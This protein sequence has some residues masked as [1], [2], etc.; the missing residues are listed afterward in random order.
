[1]AVVGNAPIYSLLL[2]LL[3]LLLHTVRTAAKLPFFRCY[4]SCWLL[5]HTVLGLLQGL[6]LFFLAA[7]VMAL[8]KS[9]LKVCLLPQD[10]LHQ[11]GGGEE[12]EE[13][14]ELRQPLPQLWDLAWEDLVFPRVLSL[15]SVEDLFRLRAACRQAHSMVDTY[16]SMSRCLRLTSR[17]PCTLE[18]LKVGGGG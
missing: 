11:A 5:L 15:L 2:Q 17:R 7:N 8:G 3:L 12:Q 4:C 18:A 9:F 16:F 10:D 13:D 14:F 6:H 1:M